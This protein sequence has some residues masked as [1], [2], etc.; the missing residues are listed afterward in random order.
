MALAKTSLAIFLHEHRPMNGEAFIVD[1]YTRACGSTTIA[2]EQ[3]PL[4][5]VLYI[6]ETRDIIEEISFYLVK[7]NPF[8]SLS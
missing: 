8:L 3:V 7:M 4:S 1:F 5:L 6:V 2:S